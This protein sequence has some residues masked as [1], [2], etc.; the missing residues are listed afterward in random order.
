MIIRFVRVGEEA[1]EVEVSN[2]IGTGSVV[3]FLVGGYW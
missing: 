2:R 1:F 3:F